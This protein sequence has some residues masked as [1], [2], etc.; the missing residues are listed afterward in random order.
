ML[1]YPDRKDVRARY[2]RIEMDK[3][4]ART[5]ATGQ[6]G[7]AIVDRGTAWILVRQAKAF[8]NV[9][10]D[11]RRIA[12]VIAEV[13]SQSFYPQLKIVSFALILRSPNLREKLMG[14]TR[15][16]T[17]GQHC[18]KRPLIRRESHLLIT[19]PNVTKHGIDPQFAAPDHPGLGKLVIQ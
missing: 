10:N 19:A 13:D 2:H 12:W 4:L 9:T 14:T 3:R 7:Q 15:A 18:K 17:S 1:R 6:P 11:D 8:A 16:V 5:A